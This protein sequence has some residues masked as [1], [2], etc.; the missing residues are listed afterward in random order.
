MAAVLLADSDMINDLANAPDTAFGE[1]SGFYYSSVINKML[2]GQDSRT[3]RDYWRA[4]VFGSG[5]KSLR[6]PYQQIDGGYLWSEHSLGYQFCCTSKPWEAVVAAM[7]L[8]PDLKIAINKSELEAY[9]ERWRSIGFYTEEDTCAPARGQCSGGANSG[10]SCS[11]ASP[12]ACGEGS[13]DLGGSFEA[14]YG[15]S[16]GPDPQSPGQCIV[17]TDDSDGIGRIPHFHGTHTADG[18][19]GSEFSNELWDTYL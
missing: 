7:N 4:I 1:T 11:T 3:E 9:V 18:Y 13:C 12:D 16:Y 6:D 14:E 5:S 19:Y 2:W 17:D 15:V 10:A 8:M